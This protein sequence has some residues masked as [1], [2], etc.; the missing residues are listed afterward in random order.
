MTMTG[1]GLTN[2]KKVKVACSYCKGEG[3]II[4]KIWGRIKCPVWNC[5]GGVITRKEKTMAELDREFKAE[6]DASNAQSLL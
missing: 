6:Q 2:M 5:K 1:C 3:F 4:D